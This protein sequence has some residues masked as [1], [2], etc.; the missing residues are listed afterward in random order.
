MFTIEM[1]PAQQG[2]A[3][4]IEYGDPN[5]PSRVLIDAGT[6]PTYQ[7]VKA[8][9]LRPAPGSGNIELFIVTHIDT[10]HIGG[11]LKLLADGDL[12]LEFGDVWFNAWR[13][14]GADIAGDRLGPID[15]EILSG[16]LDRGRRRWNEAFSGGPAAV[17]DEGPLTTWELAGGMTVTLLSPG[18]AQLLDLRRKW[19]N[20]V[21]DAGLDPCQ[22]GR[23]QEILQIL[24]ARKGVRLDRLGAEEINVRKLAESAFVPDRA[25]ANGSTIAVLAEFDGR[26]ALLGGDGFADVI[27]ANV[28]RLAQERGRHKLAIDA[29]KLP[30]HGSRHNLNTDLLSALTCRKYLF[31]T[32]GAIFGHP[33]RET[34]ARII[35][36]GGADP[37]LFFNYRTPVNAVWDDPSLMREFGYKVAY[38]AGDAPGLIVSL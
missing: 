21:K 30:H 26:S 27:A 19:T 14:L 38:P 24:A 22:P 29:I 3:L 34:V 11:A 10:D 12:G 8:R 4:W 28:R 2:D 16:L 1:L 35:V 13:H 31:S 23:A 5:A 15:G 32:N 6:P 33:D 36:E 7:M 9:I 20:V 17:R 25:E 18:P 37:T